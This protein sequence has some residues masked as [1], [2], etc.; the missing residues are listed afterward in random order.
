MV[1]M[2]LVGLLKVGSVLISIQEAMQEQ[3]QVYVTRIV[4]I[5]ELMMV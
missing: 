1:A 5:A 4:V 3:V 2:F